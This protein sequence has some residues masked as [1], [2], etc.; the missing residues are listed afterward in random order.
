M[1]HFLHW[2]IIFG[3]SFQKI[4]GLNLAIISSRGAVHFNSTILDILST[5][6]FT[7]LKY[8]ILFSGSS[9]VF[10]SSRFTIIL[11]P[12]SALSFNSVKLSLTFKFNRFSNSSEFISLLT[13]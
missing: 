5:L 7:I 3:F 12:S 9:I 2:D 13:K 4:G 6:W 1:F 8:K 11:F 10:E